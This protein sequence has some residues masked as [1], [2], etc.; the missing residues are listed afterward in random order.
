MISVR[1]AT[2]ADAAAIAAIYAF[3]VLHGTATLEIDPPSVADWQLKIETILP[4]GWPFVVAVNGADVVGYA[5]ATQ[6][7]DRAAY[8]YSCENSIYIAADRR[9]QDIGKILLAALVQRAEAF[10]F[11]QMLA[12]VGGGDVIELDATNWVHK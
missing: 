11:R 6:F 1:A 9:G 2:S 7:R 3:H 4:K 5:S 8:R 10:D 12:V